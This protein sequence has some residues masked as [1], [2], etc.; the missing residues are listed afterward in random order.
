MAKHKL[1][2]DD[3]FDFQLIGI[4]SSHS[5]YRL[6]W[7]INNALHINL[8]KGEDYSVMAKKDGEHLHS[9]YE[10]YDKEEHIEY[11]LIKNVSSN[12]Q[13]L[14]PEKD[15]V[16]YFLVIK[17]NFVR[18][19]NDILIQLKEIESILTAFIFDPGELKSKS[20]LVF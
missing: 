5:D 13:R 12:Y 15:Q 19:I 7:G 2:L 18:E 17:N 1:S 6:C 8:T 3:E 16:D 20:N 14:I 11:Y 10:Y 4:C 9:F